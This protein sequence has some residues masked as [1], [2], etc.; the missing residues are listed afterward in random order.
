MRIALAVV[1]ALF[2]SVTCVFAGGQTGNVLLSDCDHKDADYSA[3]FCEGY[4]DGILDQLFEA[5]VFCPPAGVNLK[6]TKD[7]VIKFLRDKPELR[8]LPAVYLVNEATKIFA[9]HN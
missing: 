3:G 2:A 6:Q 4:I 5:K 1:F 7:I 9:C 8:H